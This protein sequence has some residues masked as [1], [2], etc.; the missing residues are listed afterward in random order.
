M[1]KLR[2]ELA[3]IVER[4]V[5]SSA[6][7]SAITLDA[8]GEAIGARAISHE[9]VDAMLAALEAR[10]VEVVGPEGGGGEARLRRALDAARLLRAELGRAPNVAQIAARSGLTEDEV[11]HALALA[12]VMQR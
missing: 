10:G 5:A 6:G 8:L 9:E 12:R 1:T 4:L 7:S 2:R 3:D 11:R